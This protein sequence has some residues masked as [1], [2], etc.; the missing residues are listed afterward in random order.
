M[1]RAGTVAV[2]LPGAFYYLGETRLPPVG[3]LRQ[4]GVPI[5]VASDFNPG[6]SPLLSLRLAMS[7]ACTLFG[8]TAEEAI[9]GLTRHAAAALGRDDHLGTLEVGKQADLAVWDIE[10]PAELA[11]G[12][13]HNPCVAVYLSGKP[14]A[15]S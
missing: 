8:L 15:V 7:M 13:G 4:E 10:S 11:Y 2:L 3:L 5:A 12:V 14:I 9:A 6:S 1:A